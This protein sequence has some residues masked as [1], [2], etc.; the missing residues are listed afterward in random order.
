MTKISKTAN[1]LLNTDVLEPLIQ[2]LQNYYT[3]ETIGF[4]PVWVSK[5]Q[6][7]AILGPKSVSKKNIE[8]ISK[9][10]ETSYGLSNKRLACPFSISPFKYKAENGYLIHQRIGGVFTELKTLKS[11]SG[12]G[13]KSEQKIFKIKPL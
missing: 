8:A 6:L 2:A 10:L 4:N 3:T 5:D 12:K 11:K 9:Y 13:N 1:Q 7:K